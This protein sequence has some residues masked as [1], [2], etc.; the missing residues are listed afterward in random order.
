MPRRKNQTKNNVKKSSLDLPIKKKTAKPK[1]SALHQRT[2]ITLEQFQQTVGNQ[3]TAQIIQQLNQTNALSGLLLQQENIQFDHTHRRINRRGLLTEIEAK[4]KEDG[5]VMT[6]GALDFVHVLIDD[7]ENQ[8]IFQNKESLIEALFRSEL[9]YRPLRGPQL[10]PRTL[11]ER[12]SFK[13]DANKIEIGEGQARRH[14]ISSSSLGWAIEKSLA[15][16]DELDKQKKLQAVNGFLQRHGEQPYDTGNLEK[17]LA[18]ASRQVW[19]KTHNHVG[20]LWLGET[21]FNSV[22][23]FIRSTLRGE[24]KRLREI[25]QNDP[26]AKVDIKSIYDNVVKPQGPGMQQAIAT[27]LWEAVA[28]DLQDV[29]INQAGKEGQIM[30]ELAINTLRDFERNADLD[31]PESDEQKL[32]ENQGYLTSIIEV[33]HDLMLAGPTH[34]IFR[35][36]GG[37]DRFL[38]LDVGLAQALKQKQEQSVTEMN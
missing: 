4:I 2:L 28:K 11:G 17:D 14:V 15:G 9:L 3:K 7:T 13:G 21:R 25:S 22:R 16:S 23:G 37:L 29:L 35:V 8:Y 24:Q 34:D 36:D 20:N 31:L 38:K 18:A 12:P 32:V 1:G 19:E 30:P 27:K 26:K 33:Y 6:N 5:F 10:G